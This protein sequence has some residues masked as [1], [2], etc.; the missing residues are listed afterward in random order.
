MA[1]GS[2]DFKS[3]L[4]RSIKFF[5]IGY[6]VINRNSGLGSI[7]IHNLWVIPSVVSY[8]RPRYGCPPTPWNI[9]SC[10]NFNIYISKVEWVYT[11]QSI[12]SDW[13]WCHVTF[14]LIWILA[15]FRIRS[16]LYFTMISQ[17]HSFLKDAMVIYLFFGARI[18]IFD[19][20][21]RSRKWVQTGLSWPRWN[22]R[23]FRELWL[24]RGCCNRYW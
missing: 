21:L 9:K 14:P 15:K 13:S 5:L 10:W 16:D 20:L 12:K 6:F 3:I 8:Y 19:L 2:K 18:N 22:I 24:Y 7:K 17:I 23:Q 4:S 11:V 1:F